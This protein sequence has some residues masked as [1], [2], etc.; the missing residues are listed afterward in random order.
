MDRRSENR[1]PASETACISVAGNPAIRRTNVRLLEVSASGC[2]L[3]SDLYLEPG[4]E[5]LLTLTSLI[6]IGTVRHCQD[7]GNNRFRFG[8]LI[9]RR[10]PKDEE[11]EPALEQTV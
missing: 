10:W 9:S 1:Y 11:T 4:T 6:L 5:I 3:E 8:I 7:A 2:R